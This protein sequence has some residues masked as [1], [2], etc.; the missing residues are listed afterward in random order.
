MHS[1]YKSV[2]LEAVVSFAFGA[3]HAELLDRGE[4]YKVRFID[5]AK[6]GSGIRRGRGLQENGTK[7]VRRV[8]WDAQFS[9]NTKGTVPIDISSKEFRKGCLE[10]EEGEEGRGFKEKGPGKFAL[11][12]WSVKMV[13]CFLQAAVR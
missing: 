8:P 11:T 12:T 7:R 13:V 3:K 2:I 5:V 10:V 9:G 4:K 6:K 1:G